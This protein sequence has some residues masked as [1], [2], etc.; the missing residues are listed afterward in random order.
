VRVDA[1][2]DGAEPCAPRPG[3]FRPSAESGD[4][5]SAAERAGGQLRPAAWHGRAVM[6]A[7]SAATV[8]LAVVSTAVPGLSG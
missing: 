5:S 2:H 1:R 7:I 3:T 8:I 6:V 4:H